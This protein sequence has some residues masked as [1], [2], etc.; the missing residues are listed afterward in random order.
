M[1][2][3]MDTELPR[4]AFFD[5]FVSIS[6]LIFTERKLIV[7]PHLANSNRY[8]SS[9]TMITII[10]FEREVALYVFGKSLRMNLYVKL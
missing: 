6:P 3:E 8:D 5:R 1:F 10:K 2:S 7:Q 9:K 4:M